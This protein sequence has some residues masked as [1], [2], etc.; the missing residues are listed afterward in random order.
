MYLCVP[1]FQFFR[2]KKHSENLPVREEATAK[3]VFSTEKTLHNIV[4][5]LIAYQRKVLLREYGFVTSF[6]KHV[7]V[8]KSFHC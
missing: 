2:N 8:V 5:S 6:V 7:V 1:G 4:D 3:P